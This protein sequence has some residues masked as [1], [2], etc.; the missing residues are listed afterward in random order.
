MSGVT[1]FMG[2]GPHFIQPVCVGG[3]LGPVAGEDERLGKG[4][5]TICPF[6][7]VVW[8]PGD[9]TCL[10]AVVS[11]RGHYGAHMC[12]QGETGALGYTR[13]RCGGHM[14]SHVSLQHFLC[15]HGGVLSRHVG[16]TVLTI[17][18]NWSMPQRLHPMEGQGLS[19][20]AGQGDTL[21][22]CRQHWRSNSGP[23]VCKAFSHQSRHPG[24]PRAPSGHPFP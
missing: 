5:F 8:V 22:S 1:K 16:R 9:C 4:G 15:A 23:H 24:T 13:E 6:L 17:L 7:A 14:C 10:V 18:F 20:A 3:S 2:N 19:S 11:T 21:G 12:S